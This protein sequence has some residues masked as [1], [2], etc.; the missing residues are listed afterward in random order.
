MVTHT[1][2]RHVSS[3]LHSG[4]KYS[5]YIFREKQELSRDFQSFFFFDIIMYWLHIRFAAMYH[6]ICIV[7][8]NSTNPINK[9]ALVMLI[10]LESKV[11]ALFLCFF[12]L[13]VL[14]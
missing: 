5:N 2:H 11:H 7:A 4:H 3:Y 10:E 9:N 12:F 1:I 14:A 8:T 6:H 13:F